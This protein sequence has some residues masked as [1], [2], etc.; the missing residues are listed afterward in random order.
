M[1]QTVLFLPLA[2]SLNLL[3]LRILVL[4]FLPLVLPLNLLLSLLA[5]PRR[6]QGGIHIENV[7]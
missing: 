6:L 7:M 1:V 4:L 2:L 3:L 5:L